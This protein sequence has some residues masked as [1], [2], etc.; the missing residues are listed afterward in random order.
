M[1]A[2]TLAKLVCLAALS[3]GRPVEPSECE[4]RANEIFAAA[5]RHSVDPV[6][7]L[8]IDAWECDLRQD[9]DGLVYDRGKLVAID[10]C[11]MGYRFRDV[12]RRRQIST[13]DLYELAA[14]KL[15]DDR[16]RCRTAGH[17]HDFVSHWNLGNRR[18]SVQVLALVGALLG[19]PP[20]S[21]VHLTSRA[22][23]IVKRFLLAVGRSGNPS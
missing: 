7:M 8:G 16:R 2:A 10:A 14:A 20:K 13:A 4:Q 21:R 18:Y 23:D 6:L 17:R 11:P 22:R 19:K 5:A 12:A 3:L 15:E 1:T 9:R